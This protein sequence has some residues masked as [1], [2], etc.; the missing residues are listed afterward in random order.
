[1]EMNEWGVICYYWFMGKNVVNPVDEIEGFT[2]FD[3]YMIDVH[4]SKFLVQKFTNSGFGEAVIIAGGD[5]G[6]EERWSDQQQHGIEPHQQQDHR[7]S[8]HL[9]A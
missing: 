9:R 6:Q 3:D 4:Q 7:G 1:M 2:D 8:D 5:G